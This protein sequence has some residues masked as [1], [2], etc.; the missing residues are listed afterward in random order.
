MNPLAKSIAME[1][2]VKISAAIL[3]AYVIGQ[4]P[5][6]KAWIQA[7]WGGATHNAA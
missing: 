3:A 5:Q 4:A 7:Q 2:V 6:L 1:T